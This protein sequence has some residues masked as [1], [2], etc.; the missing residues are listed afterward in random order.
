[1]RVH[2]LEA[3]IDPKPIR[4]LADRARLVPVEDR[5]AFAGDRLEV[6]ARLRVVGVLFEPVEGVAGDLQGRLVMG[7][8]VDDARGIEDKSRTVDMLLGAECRADLAVGTEDPVE[9]ARGT[10]S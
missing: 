1:V 10:V 4:P 8:L 5:L 2:R 9:P 3:I 6:A 7:D